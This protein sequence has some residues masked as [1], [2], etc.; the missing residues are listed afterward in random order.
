[1]RVHVY[2]TGKGRSPGVVHACLHN[3]WEPHPDTAIPPFWESRAGEREHTW[4][5][6]LTTRA[7][8]IPGPADADT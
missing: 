1:M 7:L 6:P 4:F 8:M 3:R 5:Y 2:S